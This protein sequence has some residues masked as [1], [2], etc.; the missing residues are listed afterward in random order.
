MVGSQLHLQ[1]ENRWP[2]R[3]ER[4]R[5]DAVADNTT[6]EQPDLGSTKVAKDSKHDG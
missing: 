6:I 3:F 5:N 2:R 1:P 4:S